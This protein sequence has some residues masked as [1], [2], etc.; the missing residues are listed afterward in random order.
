MTVIR[1]I[2]SISV[3]FELQDSG[4]EC[5]AKSVMVNVDDCMAAANHL[6]QTW[7][8]ELNIG[9]FPKGCYLNEE[10]GGVYFNKHHTGA[11]DEFAAP[12]C[13]KNESKYFSSGTG[14]IQHFKPTN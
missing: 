13:Y 2:S 6:D 7:K 14:S 9:Q 10:N 3:D 1:Y 11:A 12:I 4:T 8:T 5:Q